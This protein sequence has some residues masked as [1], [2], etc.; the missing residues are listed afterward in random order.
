M[1]INAY[2]NFS[3]ESFDIESKLP[4]IGDYFRG[5]TVQEINEFWI[6]SAQP[7]DECWR[8][9]FYEIIT[10]DENY[11]AELRSVDADVETGL[12]V[13]K[14]FVAVEKPLKQN[15]R[16]ES[17][18]M[19][20]YY[21]VWANCCIAPHPIER[22]E[23]WQVKEIIEETVYDMVRGG[24]I[25]RECGQEEVEKALKWFE[26]IDYFGCGDFCLVASEHPKRPN[27]CCF[28]TDF[29]D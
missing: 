1:K 28:T 18:N 17:P 6:D 10:L 8:Y 12:Y 23:D 22:I 19:K 24:T 7:N 25:D 9:D 11:I 29:L 3:S 4:E 5:E 21:K 26:K 20:E 27:V 2:I 14:C 16:G 13:N 15:K